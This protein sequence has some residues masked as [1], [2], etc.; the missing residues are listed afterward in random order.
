MRRNRRAK[1]VAT[2]GPAS[3]SPD[4]LEALL[5]VLSLGDYQG[6][7]TLELSPTL[8]DPVGALRDGAALVRQLTKIDD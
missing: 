8:A 2:V 3:G 7:V 4:M 1:I 6:A 5:T